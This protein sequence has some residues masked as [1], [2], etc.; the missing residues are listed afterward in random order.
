MTT[1]RHMQ[2]SIEHEKAARENI[3]LARYNGMDLVPRKA[4]TTPDDGLWNRRPAA[5]LAMCRRRH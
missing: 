2:L 5:R 4:I 3:T 1:N